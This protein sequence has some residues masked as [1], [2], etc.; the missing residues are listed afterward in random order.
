MWL[1]K[2]VGT[3]VNS[4]ILDLLPCVSS[5]RAAKK[6]FDGMGFMFTGFFTG[7]GEIWLH[8]VITQTPG[9]RHSRGV[10]Q[11]GDRCTN[12]YPAPRMRSIKLYCVY[13]CMTDWLEGLLVTNKTAKWL[14]EPVRGVLGRAELFKEPSSP[15][16]KLTSRLYILYC[17]TPS[18]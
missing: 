15:R 10:R 5:P 18:G 4:S 2:I 14:P 8:T 16:S 1:G 12:N 9:H 13:L 7:E 17:Y 6:A 3:C 11:R